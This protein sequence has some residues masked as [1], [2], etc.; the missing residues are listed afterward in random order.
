MKK[1][2]KYPPTNCTCTICNECDCQSSQQIHE[3]ICRSKR[4]Q[5][6]NLN[7][8]NNSFK[9]FKPEI[10]ISSQIE[11]TRK[12]TLLNNHKL[13]LIKIP[14]QSDFKTIVNE[15]EMSPEKYLPCSTKELL[16][17]K[18]ICFSIYKVLKYVK[19]IFFIPIFTFQSIFI[20]INKTT[21]WLGAL[22]LCLIASLLMSTFFFNYIYNSMQ[23]FPPDE[24][25]Q[26][27]TKLKGKF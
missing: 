13:G 22:A 23:I 20:I 25:I 17:N 6:L 15:K 24:L 14:T 27:I 1:L 9:N 5:D 10:K 8:N 4:N 26:K 21:K 18:Y 16:L 11:L 12:N 7:N 3:L 19:L 2:R